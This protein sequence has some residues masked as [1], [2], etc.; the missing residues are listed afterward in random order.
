MRKGMKSAAILMLAG[1]LALGLTTM[2]FAQT[3]LGVWPGSST[4]DPA[5]T[6]AGK[7]AGPEPSYSY[8]ILGEWP[9]SSVADPAKTSAGQANGPNP[10][11][12]YSVLGV[13]PGA[14]TADGARTS[15]GAK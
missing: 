10:S 11:Y 9:G 3:I 5:K 8:S 4:A 15:A 13:W 7:A 14:S 1:A 2:S 12:S 6:A